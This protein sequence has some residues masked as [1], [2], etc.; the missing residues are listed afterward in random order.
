MH[1]RT[2][3]AE[4]HTDSKGGAGRTTVHAHSCT[5]AAVSL[6]VREWKT[7]AKKGKENNS[8]DEPKPHLCFGHL[9]KKPKIN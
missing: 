8:S 3:E 6:V 2:G 4:G 7:R 5:S 9:N 1:R